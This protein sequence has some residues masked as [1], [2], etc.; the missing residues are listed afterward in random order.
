[1][2]I[3]VSL[4]SDRTHLSEGFFGVGWNLVGIATTDPPRL[5]AVAFAISKLRFRL[6]LRL[7][8]HNTPSPMAGLPPC[9]NLINSINSGLRNKRAIISVFFMKEPWG[10]RVEEIFLAKPT[11]AIALRN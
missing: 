5:T 1:M 6:R 10:R 4:P 8:V 7:H 2:V 9:G 3:I 11:P